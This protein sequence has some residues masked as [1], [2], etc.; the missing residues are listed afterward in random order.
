MDEPVS[1]HTI[2]I[3]VPL[4]IHSRFRCF[5]ANV[6]PYLLAIGY[7]LLARGCCSLEQPSHFHQP[8]AQHDYIVMIGSFIIM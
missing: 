7:W 5:F 6:A 8:A 3:V 4:L 2:Q 1:N